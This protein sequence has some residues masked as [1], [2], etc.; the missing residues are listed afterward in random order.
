MEQIHDPPR[1]T[2]VVFW[3]GVYNQN[4]SGLL[5]FRTTFGIIWDTVI[6]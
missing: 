6:P 1:V 5:S 4:C 2:S 3:L